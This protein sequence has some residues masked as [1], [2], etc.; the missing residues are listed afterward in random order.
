VL[1]KLQDN[2]DDTYVYHNPPVARE[3]RRMYRLCCLF[4]WDAWIGAFYRRETNQMSH[5][6]EKN[7]R[8]DPANPAHE[9]QVAKLARD[10][11]TRATKTATRIIPG[12]T[13]TTP[14]QIPRRAAQ[15]EPK[16]R[17]Q[18]HTPT[19]TAVPIIISALFSHTHNSLPFSNTQATHAHKT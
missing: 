18:V 9:T 3:D 8:D 11:A 13:L 10:K 6:N 7:A 15:K 19:C 17:R 2:A 5:A 12:A 1:G 4:E 14:V 16:K